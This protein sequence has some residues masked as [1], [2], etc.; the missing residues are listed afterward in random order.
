MDD[1][2]KLVN[3]VES[4]KTNFG[5]GG[6]LICL[7]VLLAIFFLW[8]YLTKSIEK[9]AEITSEK[10]IK[11][12]QAQLDKELA[13]HS[14]KFSARHQKQIDAVHEI[15]IRVQNLFKIMDYMLHGDKYY[16]SFDQHNEVDSLIALRT[17]FIKIYGI[18]KIVLTKQVC[19]KIDNLIPS[20]EEFIDTYKSGLFPEGLQMEI[21]EPDGN[22]S[23]EGQLSIAGIWRQNAFDDTLKKLETVKNEIEDE[24]RK[25]YGT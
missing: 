7:L 1:I 12:F 15:Y 17:D 23:E 5:I 8:R 21:E 2:E 4:L 11:K 20:I 10:T 19:S 16:P 25:I 24:F 14:V 6:A 3:Q 18:H 13:E 22:K 9:S